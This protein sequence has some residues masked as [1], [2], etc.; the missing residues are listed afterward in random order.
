MNDDVL[1]N[2]MRLAIDAAR[3]AQSAGGV[4]IGAVLVSRDGEVLA[5]GGSD[6]GPTHDPTAHA[7]INCIRKV[8]KMRQMD[9]LYGTI[10]FST[11]E[12]CHM[13]L[14]AA[15]WARITDIYFGAYRKDVDESLFDIKGSFS[16]EKEAQR[17]N[18]RE[19]QT[20]EVRGGIL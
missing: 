10:L 4:A 8:A 17:M 9:D 15:A 20:M 1:S 5:V 19:K 12:P 2:Y 16:D 11:L 18:L 6:V 13:C 14:S 3:S 7:E